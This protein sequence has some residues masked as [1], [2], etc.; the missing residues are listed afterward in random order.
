MFLVLERGRGSAGVE[1]ENWLF[2][3]ILWWEGAEAGG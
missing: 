3:G 2:I 1:V